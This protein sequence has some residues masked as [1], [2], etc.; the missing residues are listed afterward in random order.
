MKP[1]GGY[2]IYIY[3][4]ICVYLI[5]SMSWVLFYGDVTST[6]GPYGRSMLEIAYGEILLV[7]LTD[8]WRVYRGLV[9]RGRIRT[10]HNNINSIKI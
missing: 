5:M 7:S 1:R 9:G 6:T 3:I 10:Y 8:L 4:C 2:V